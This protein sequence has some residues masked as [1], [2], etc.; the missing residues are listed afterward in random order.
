MIQ[1]VKVTFWAGAQGRGYEG[2][3]VKP[4]LAEDVRRFQEGDYCFSSEG[5]GP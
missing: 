1:V 5:L 2:V 3:S 4:R